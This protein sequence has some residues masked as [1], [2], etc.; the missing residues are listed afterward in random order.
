MS[1]T[2]RP[3]AAAFATH[4]VRNQVPPLEG[5]NLYLD[6]TALVEGL[7][8]EGG[9]WAHQRAAEVGAFWGGEPIAWG[10]A[11]NEHPPV[12]GIS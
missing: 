12:R 3:D 5:R 1:T 2:M 7:R 8:R 9:G 10:F 4:E 11:A 6:N